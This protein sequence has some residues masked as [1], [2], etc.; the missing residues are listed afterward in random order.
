MKLDAWSD[1]YSLSCTFI[2]PDTFA[3]GDSALFVFCRTATLD[4]ATPWPAQNVW[5]HAGDSSGLMTVVRSDDSTLTGTFAATFESKLAT[6]WLSGGAFAVRVK[7][8]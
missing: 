5:E 1:G 8:K 3:V 4:F 6:Y 7:G 2:L